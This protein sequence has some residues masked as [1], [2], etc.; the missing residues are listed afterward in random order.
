MTKEIP[1]KHPSR[2]ALGAKHVTMQDDLAVLD[3][4][5]W[6]K[7]CPNLAL[8]FRLHLASRAI[9]QSQ[10]ANSRPR[11]MPKGYQPRLKTCVWLSKGLADAW[12]FSGEDAWLSHQTVEQGIALCSA[13]KAEWGG[14]EN[15]TGTFVSKW[16]LLKEIILLCNAHIITKMKRLDSWCAEINLWTLSLSSKDELFC[17][18]CLFTDYPNESFLRLGLLEEHKKWG[19][20][21]HMET[22]QLVTL[23]SYKFVIKL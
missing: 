7:L 19:N 8:S 14:K 18:L 12:A 9:S 23:T 21:G 17:V 5:T 22:T 10:Q 16:V 13:E 20:S 4:Q 11:E 15:E 6:V 3:G 2:D 1:V